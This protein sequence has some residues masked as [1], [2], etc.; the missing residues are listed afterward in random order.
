MPSER[1]HRTGATRSTRR[2]DCR[3]MLILPL[4]RLERAGPRVLVRSSFCC[5]PRGPRAVVGQRH[6]E[7]RLLRRDLL[8]GVLHKLV[9]LL[10]VLVG[11]CRGG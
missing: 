3:P 9:G 11:L 10:D 4:Q 7:L 5:S 1:T 2:P 6:S 8:D